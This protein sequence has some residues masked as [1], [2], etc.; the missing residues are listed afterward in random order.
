MRWSLLLAGCV[1]L[2]V[3]CTVRAD[4]GGTGYQCADGVSCPAG[5]RCEAFRCVAE[6]GSDAGAGADAGFDAAVDA[7]GPAAP[8][9]PTACVTE[10][11]GGW[12]HGCALRRDGTVMCWGRNASGQL[13]D[14][15]TT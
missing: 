2:G 8:P 4:Y 12:D 14:G 7:G 9:V 13:G 1:G 15:T 5:Y 6:G 3:A 10:T 11:V